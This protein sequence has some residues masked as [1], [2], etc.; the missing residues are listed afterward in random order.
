MNNILIFILG[1]AIGY[2]FCSYVVMSKVEKTLLSAS[3]KLNNKLDVL[4]LKATTA[5]DKIDQTVKKIDDT[6]AKLPFGR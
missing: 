2:G 5:S 4:E 6:M 3:E 1:I